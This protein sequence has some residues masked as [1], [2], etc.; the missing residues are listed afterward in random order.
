MLRC[1]RTRVGESNDIEALASN[2][3]SALP[4][5]AVWNV[6]Q[7][8]IVNYCPNSSGTLRNRSDIDEKPVLSHFQQDKTII[9]SQVDSTFLVAR[10]G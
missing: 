2:K 9:G 5:V 1:G 10:H 6:R 4:Y 3:Q 8:P 7:Q